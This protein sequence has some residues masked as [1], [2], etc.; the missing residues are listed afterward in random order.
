MKIQKL[1]ILVMTL[2]ELNLYLDNYYNF[3]IISVR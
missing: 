3:H 1:F 2:Y